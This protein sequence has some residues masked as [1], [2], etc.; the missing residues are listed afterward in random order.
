MDDYD[1]EVSEVE[2]LEKFS[3]V[4]AFPGADIVVK[5]EENETTKE[6]ENIYKS[7][8]YGK[9]LA[10]RAINLQ[11]AI[12]NILQAWNLPYEL[13]VVDLEEDVFLFK[14]KGEN[15]TIRVLNHEPWCFKGHLLCLQ[16]WKP[17]LAVKEIDFS[18]SPFWVQFHGIPVA[19]MTYTTG[20]QLGSYIGEVLDVD[21]SKAGLTQGRFVRVRVLI[22]L[23][24]PLRPWIMMKRVYPLPDLKIELKFE[25]V[26]S[27]CFF[28]GRIGH[29]EKCCTMKMRMPEKLIDSFRSGC[30]NNNPRADAYKGKGKQKYEIQSS[31]ISDHSEGESSKMA[32]D[33]QKLAIVVTGE[34]D[35]Q[36]IAGN[37]FNGLDQKE[38]LRNENQRSTTRGIYESSANVRTEASGLMNNRD[39]IIW[40]NDES[41]QNGRD[42]SMRPVVGQRARL[43]EI[44][45]VVT[46]SK[47]NHTNTDAVRY[48]KTLKGTGLG[49][50][51]FLAGSSFLSGVGKRISI[52][53]KAQFF[54][55]NGE[56]LQQRISS[57]EGIV[58]S[59]KI[60]TREE[61]EKATDN[62]N[63]RLIVG[64][65]GYGTVY[66]GTLPNYNIVAIKKSKLVDESQIEQFINEVV[67]L[68]QINHRN[69]VKLLG[70]CLETEVPLLIYEFV[71]NGTLFHH[72]HDTS[73]VASLSWESRL[74]IAA[75]TAGAVAYFHSAASIPI[76]HRDIKSTNILLDENY[77]AKVTDFGAS[78][79][80]PPDQTYLTTLV[81]G[82]LGYLDP[83]YFH[84]GQ[85]TEKSDV[86]SFGVV[87]IELL[88]GK[89]AFSNERYEEKRNLAMHFV[90]S[91]KQNRLSEVLEERVI[92]EGSPQHLLEIAK[93]AESCVRLQ[94]DRRP[95]MKEVAVGLEGLWRIVKYPC[96]PE[97][98]E[99]LLGEQSDSS[100]LLFDQ[101][102]TCSF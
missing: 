35:R 16:R 89:K 92:Q 94:R 55:K 46:P 33:R 97:E 96:A 28:C 56:L 80:I 9:F 50:L 65:G 36:E 15:D 83:E 45:E 38:H 11:L 70:C 63:E 71:N 1:E 75:E 12:K 95:T 58:G 85:L 34:D 48:G 7:A 69:V 25:K 73:L 57:C 2:L 14:F 40:W 52:K 61:L 3:Y 82:T 47:R 91:M 27:F 66:K 59:I 51:F 10:E 8:L 44:T 81:Q 74:R 42:T 23:D 13:E 17:D 18:R 67:T 6:G 99:Y 64:R 22:Q 54:R 86:Y 29:E 100:S 79:L 53:P 76:I 72:I 84:S 20:N 49:R 102:E 43:E 5:I 26:P 78:R 39:D 88:T 68:S 19:K 4:L 60:F 90:S 30:S 101:S 87:L 31:E 98:T 93:L 21:L 62:Y 32:E 24:K 37:R 41:F 77:R